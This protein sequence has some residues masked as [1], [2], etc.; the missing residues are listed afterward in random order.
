[1]C[2]RLDLRMAYTKKKEKEIVRSKGNKGCDV[3]GDE[4][5]FD[6]RDISNDLERANCFRKDKISFGSSGAD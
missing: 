2:K 4:V 3:E 1:M 6:G 5:P